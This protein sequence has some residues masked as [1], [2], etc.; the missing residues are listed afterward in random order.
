MIL[1][2]PYTERLP[3][4]L[5]VEDPILRVKSDEL[6]TVILERLDVKEERRE[7]MARFK[8]RIGALDE[9]ERDL[10]LEV[11]QKVKLVEVKVEKRLK[12]GT[13]KLTIVRLDTGKV[14]GER[15]ATEKDL[16]LAQEDLPAVDKRPRSAVAPGKQGTLLDAVNT[17]LDQADAKR[18]AAEGGTAVTDKPTPGLTVEGTVDATLEDLE[19][20]AGELGEPVD[21]LGGDVPDQGDQGGDLGGD[22]DMGAEHVSEP[23]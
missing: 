6:A 1:G 5:D 4:P 8:E 12:R 11:K 15:E 20:A 7:A 17:G 9:R 13:R 16:K 22:E 19:E 18:A 3:V 23:H 2:K 21:G 10:A 14:I